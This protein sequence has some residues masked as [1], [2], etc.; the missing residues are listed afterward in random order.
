MKKQIIIRCI[1]LCV[2]V[3]LISGAAS[4]AIL[5]NNKE[6]S[7]VTGMRDILK[8][9]SLQEGAEKQ[10]YN[11][12]AERYSELS[13]DYRITVLDKNGDVLGD[14]A[15]DAGAMENHANRPEIKQALAAGLGYEKRPSDTLGEAMLYV[16]LR[17]G[18]IIYRIAAPVDTIN[19]TAMDLLPAL[20]AGLALALLVAP[21]LAAST[22]KSLIKPLS[23]VADALKT[24]DDE[25][26]NVQLPLPVYEELQPIAA[27]I[28]TL[29]SNIADT[30]RELSEEREKTEYLL[31]SMDSGLILVGNDL[32]VLHINPAAE[33]FLGERRNA[34]GKNLL[35]LTRQMKLIT[36][37]KNAIESG[38]SSIFDVEGAAEGRILSVHVTAVRS[39]WLEHGRASG[40]VILIADVTQERM[41]E[42]MRSEFVANAS[43]ELKTPITSIGGFAELLAAGVVEEPGKVKEYLTRIKNETQRMALL[44][45]DILKLS[46]LENGGSGEQEY[47]PVNLREQIN[48][49]VENMQPQITAR[50]VTVN[51]NAA[52]VTINAVPDEMEA[53]VQNLID[54]AV[55]YNREGGTVNVTLEQLGGGARLTVSDD[56]IGIPYEDQTRIFERFYRVDKGRS[57]KVG[58]TGLG[59]AIVKHVAAKYGGGLTL[60]SAAGKGTT[61]TV[62]VSC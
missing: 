6:Q 35:V 8:T 47:E 28:N 55:K 58:G 33:G 29:T 62:T 22:A 34:E 38:S 7:I 39:Q 41:T 40:A 2:A 9:I 56:G 48:E 4:A 13:F 12:L 45:E 11:A 27:S 54:N 59:L 52:E 49:V 44:I 30:M 61:I 15:A 19:A 53:L 31:S 17:D 1:F 23:D 57:R 46:C 50:G 37:V 21:V 25:N 43:H 14:S 5:Q 51:V 26:Y 32:R 18:D 16:A 60:Q 20:L 42:R 36:A 10:D 3:V 24:L